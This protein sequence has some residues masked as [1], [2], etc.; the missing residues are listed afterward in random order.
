ML[1]RQSVAQAVKPD[2]SV[3]DIVHAAKSAYLRLGI[4]SYILTDDGCVLCFGSDALFGIQEV[5]GELR[6]SQIGH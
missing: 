4:F 1:G 2:G 3:H 6:F 5:V